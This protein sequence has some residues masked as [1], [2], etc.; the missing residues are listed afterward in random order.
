MQVKFRAVGFLVCLVI[1]NVVTAAINTDMF[2]KI[3]QKNHNFGYITVVSG[4]PRS[5][6]SMMMRMLESGGMN[7]LSDGQRE[8]DSDNPKGYYE[9]ERVKQLDSGDKIWVK[10]AQGKAVKVIATLVEH[11]PKNYRYRL[12]FMS[13]DIE[14]IVA[15][16]YKMLE[17]RSEVTHLD[18]DEIGHVLEK[19]RAQIKF[20]LVQQ[21]N[22]QILEVNY[23]Q[24][25][26]EPLPEV[27]KLNH[28]LKGRLDES[29]MKNV[30]D[31]NL[32]RNRKA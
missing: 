15:S 21:P 20:W 25:L 1:L 31:I 22:F 6:T 4:L 23:N 14:E 7:I 12:I 9:F 10:D 5:G 29:A 28:F 26:R 13:R 19:H 30:V 17:N 18:D 16:Q 27:A 2:E 8:A 24:L 32:Y 11:L 3:F